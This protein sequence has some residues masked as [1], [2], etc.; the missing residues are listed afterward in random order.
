[1]A[2]VE[3]VEDEECS[4]YAAMEH[5]SGTNPTRIRHSQSVETAER[6]ARE[7]FAKRVQFF[8]EYIADNR[9]TASESS[10]SN[11]QVH[12]I[13]GNLTLFNIACYSH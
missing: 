12:E 1:M 8:R 3:E 2:T 4:G 5:P 6:H 9:S 13:T 7:D 10:S 11:V